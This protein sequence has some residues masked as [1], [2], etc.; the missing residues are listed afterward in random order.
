M[1]KP[2]TVALCLATLLLLPSCSPRD[3]LTRRL[4]ADLIAASDT[5]AAPQS[6]QL[7]TGIISNQDHLS[8]DY[9]ILQHHGWIAAATAPCPPVL[10]PPPCWDITLTPS[11]VDAFQNLIPPGDAGKATF[12]ISAARR[13]FV[14]ITGI[15]KQGNTADVDFSWKWVPLNELGAALYP[16]DVRYYS[17][18]TF[19]CYDDGWRLVDRTRHRVESLDDELKNAQPAH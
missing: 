9:I 6:F 18:A 10:G 13:E 1:R 14:A 16:S 17:T 7:R 8:S 3:F 11:G 2:S 19:R 15:A 4:A 12:T 5:F